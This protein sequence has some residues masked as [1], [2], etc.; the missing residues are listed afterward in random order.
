LQLAAENINLAVD[1]PECGPAFDG[2]P[3]PV[4]IIAANVFEHIERELW[5]AWSEMQDEEEEEVDNDAA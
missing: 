4:N 3:T 2:S 1:T 5:D